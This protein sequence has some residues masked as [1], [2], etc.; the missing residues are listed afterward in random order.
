MKIITNQQ[1]TKKLLKTIKKGGCI[2]K[3]VKK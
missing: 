3:K 2:E 1:K